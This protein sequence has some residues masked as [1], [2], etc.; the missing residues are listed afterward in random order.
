MM[1][2][3]RRLG[4]GLDSLVSDIR[5]LEVV[6]ESQASVH[7][8]PQ[9]DSDRSD[10]GSPVLQAMMIDANR[11]EPNPFQPRDGISEES[12]ASLARSIHQSGLLQPI[13]VR[14]HG[15]RWQIIAGERRWRAA[16]RIGLRQVPVL[17]RE[18]SEEQMLELALVENLQREDLN[19]IDR[20]AAYRQFCTRFALKPEQVADRLGE[21]RTTVL[22]YLRL[23]DLPLS[24]RKLI[25]EGKLGVGHARCL[26]GMA[27][28][29]RM[30]AL[31]ESAAAN[32]LSVRALEEIVR[33]EKGRAAETAGEESKPTI[34][35]RS[36][37]IR[38]MQRRFEEAVKTKVS[39]QEGK[40]K[41][42]G[43]IVIEYY[44][45]DDFDRIA[46]LLGVD[47]D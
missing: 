4:R 22:N 35:L 28:E 41:G 20:G 25:V 36:A 1:K 42:S 29:V 2:S 24:V 16:K 18:A 14:R 19:A 32:Q 43:R 39:I 17:V 33:K 26:I 34:K 40:R 7:P 13:A 21:D 47:A 10:G 46:E 5:G 44:S 9:S 11:L 12:V 38:D 27:D 8:V 23:L 37:H 31:A 3:Q 45:L 6:E 30:L 15:D